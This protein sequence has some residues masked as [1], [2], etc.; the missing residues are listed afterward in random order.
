MRWLTTALLLLATG[1]TSQPQTPVTEQPSQA[2]SPK[3]ASDAATTSTVAQ[4]ELPQVVSVGDGDTL[5]VKQGGK[6]ISIRL[7]CID[8]PESTQTPWGQQSANRLKQL[9]PASQAVQMREIDRDR[10]GRTVAELYLGNQSVNLTMIKEGQAVVY[11]QY[12]QGCS[13]TK[14]QYQAAESQAKAQKLG[15]WN[16]PNPVM[17]WDYRRG[18]RSNNQPSSGG[19]PRPKPKPST[20]ASPTP[21]T[22]TTNLPACTNSDCDCKDFKTQAEAKRVLDA[23]PGDPFDLDRDKDNIACESLP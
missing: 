12:L 19:N 13:D 21:T 7:G 14:D 22:S 20:T 15:Y 4:N 8:A 17:P 18:K 1:C 16:Q 3:A 11:T 5:R 23:F 10:Y 2:I 9:L 6:T